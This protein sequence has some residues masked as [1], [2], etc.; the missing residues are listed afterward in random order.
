MEDPQL[1]LPRP[2]MT[3]CATL[4]ASVLAVLCMVCSDP[5]FAVDVSWTNAAGGLWSTPGNWSTNS[6]PG[7]SDRALITLSGTYTVTLDANASVA[8]LVLGAGSGQQTLSGSSRNITATDSVSV[9]TSG[10]LDL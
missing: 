7:P 1:P 3:R 10:V 9:A 2:S 6:V 4:L 8:A 5:A